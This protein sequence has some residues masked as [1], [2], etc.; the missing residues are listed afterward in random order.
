MLVRA[1]RPPS[2]RCLR[3]EVHP[4]VSFTSSSECCVLR[5]ASGPA[6]P[7]LAVE[8]CAPKAPPLGFSAL[9]AT[10]AGSVHTRAGCPPRA[11]VRPRRFARPRRFTPPPA[12]RVCFAPLPRTG[13]ALQGIVP[14]L[15][16]GPVSRPALPS[17]RCA[18]RSAGCPVPVTPST[19]GPCSPGG[20]GGPPAAVKPPAAPR[21]S[22]ACS[23]SGC[24]PRAPCVRPRLFGRSRR[25]RLRPSPR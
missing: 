12:L 6:P 2:P 21:P 14:R 20:C 16:H 18:P 8:R 11:S 25:I 24:S 15:E 9:F 7:D 5:P 22:W 4:S 10:S 3:V 19:P 17:C 1:C 13:F 23:S